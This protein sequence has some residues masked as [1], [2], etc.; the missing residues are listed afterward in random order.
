MPFTD[1]VAAAQCC[2]RMALTPA[3]FFA[4]AVFIPGTTRRLA[5]N[6]VGSRELRLDIDVG[7]E[8][9]KYR[10]L[11]EA[12][13]ALIRFS[14]AFLP[15]TMV[16]LSGGGLHVYWLV[17]TLMPK[18]VWCDLAGRLDGATMALGLLTDRKCTAGP[19]RVLRPITTFNYKERAPRQVTLLQAGPA[20][21]VGQLTQAL[22][23][24]EPVPTSAG[25]V[26]QQAGLQ[27]QPGTPAK[28][29]VVFKRVGGP[30]P[31]GVL[32]AACQVVGRARCQR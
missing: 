19:E 8:P 4:M 13:A 20:Y 22:Q 21:M 12:T 11:Q 14:K 23:K 10:T 3:V 31:A 24:Y 30:E 17:P 26:D 25:Q 5:D 7:T 9:G 27:A 29:P 32:P 16:L 6:V 2:V 1:P 18:D 28:P 15:P